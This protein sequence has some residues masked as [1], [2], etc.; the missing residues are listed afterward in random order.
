[1]RRFSIVVVLMVLW[2]YSASAQIPPLV[3]GVTS[4]PQ[5]NEDGETDAAARRAMAPPQMFSKANAKPLTQLENTRDLLSAAANELRKISMNVSLVGGNKYMVND[6]LGVKASAG[7]ITV[8][9]SLPSVRQEGSGVVMVFNIDRITLD[10]L[11]IRVRPNPNVA[12]LCKFSKKFGV[13]GAA[14]NVRLEFRVDPLLD[15]QQCRVFFGGPLRTSFSIGGLN[16][17]PL[18]NDLDRV[19]KNMIEDALNQMIDGN[20]PD[21]MR[22]AWSRALGATSCKPGV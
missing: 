4:S 16:L 6:C 2:T 15:L 3:R 7:E 17:K 14:S 13:G 19:A 10:G 20:V 12:K 9:P 21:Q 1:M 11:M 22:E 18:Q 8:T 5:E